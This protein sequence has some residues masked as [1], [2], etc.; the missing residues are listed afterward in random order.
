MLRNI[1]P[2]STHRIIYNLG[3]HWASGSVAFLNNNFS[4]ELSATQELSF[5]RLKDELEFVKMITEFCTWFRNGEKASFP[6][7]HDNVHLICGFF[8]VDSAILVE[9]AL[10]YTYDETL[11]LSNVFNFLSTL[12]NVI[13]AC[14]NI[15]FINKACRFSK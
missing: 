6:G 8:S 3:E 13:V 10:K 1:L 11:Q 12:P 5:V 15:S 9:F 2:V 14:R 4:N 7:G